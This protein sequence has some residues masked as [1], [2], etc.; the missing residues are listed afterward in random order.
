MSRK[1]TITLCFKLNRPSKSVTV[2]KWFRLP[3][4]TEQVV[5]SIPSNVGYISHVNWAYDY[6]GPFGVLWV[7]EMTSSPMKHLPVYLDFFSLR[8]PTL[9]TET[10]KQLQ[11]KQW[12]L[13]ISMTSCHDVLNTDYFTTLLS[14]EVDVT[15][16]RYF[17]F[18]WVKGVNGM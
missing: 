2:A 7:H 4:G 18:L 11:T 9:I 17:Y 10:P 13:D 14:P 1:T 5:S 16:Q 8:E 12:G 15:E 3:L 6:L